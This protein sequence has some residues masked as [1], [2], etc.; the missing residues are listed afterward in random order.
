MYKVIACSI[1]KPY[2]EELEFDKSQ[3]NFTYLKIRQHNQPHKLSKTIQKEIDETRDVNQIIVIYGICGGALL[4]LKAH[5]IPVVLV[6]VHDC[7]SILLGSKLR[8]GKL[9]ETNKS[10]NWSCYALKEEN[11]VN[12]TLE[13]WKM[14][15]DEE[16][17]EY[18]KSI[19]IV[20]NPIYISFDLSKESE[21]LRH[22][23]KVI[24]GDLT[25]LRD[26]IKLESN[27]IVILYK[28]QKVVQ[29]LDDRVI[30]VIDENVD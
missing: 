18:L 9:T 16:T 25:F 30:E 17:V 13:E 4:S 29:T 6:K 27:E 19:L 2:I 11:Y 28:N 7:M 15:Y 5:D 8:Y 12:D 3:Y 10:L 26:I 22:E 24:K 21:Y 20:D 1:F 23:Q 14:L